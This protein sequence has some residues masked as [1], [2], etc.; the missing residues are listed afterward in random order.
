MYKL[1]TA[2]EKERQSKTPEAPV[3]NPSASGE[4]RS[5][6]SRI[7]R[8]EVSQMHK[9]LIAACMALAAFAVFAIGPAT[10]SATNNPVVTHPTN[11]VLAKGAKITGTLLNGSSVLWN[12]AKTVKQLTC[13]T[14]TMEGEL[15]K[16]EGGNV[17]GSITSAIFGGTGP[18]AAG[19]PANECTG[20]DNASVTPL[21]FP[22]C[23]RSTTTMV[24]D[25]VQIS[26]GG[27]PGGGKIKFLL[28][29]TTIGECEYESTG[30]IKGTFTTDTAANGNSDAIIHVNQPAHDGTGTQGF[31]K[32]R[33][34]IF[35]PSSGV[36]EMSFTLETKSANTEPLYFS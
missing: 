3:S 8:K 9:K 12:T 34:G 35:C 7:P 10:A 19:E 21:G 32:I 30:V 18:K 33:G 15:T 25:E 6:Q 23:I 31:K 22:W 26:G 17:E 14:A 1:P 16:N 20:V 4:N 5:G 2:R 24:T 13:T 29:T 11:T 27:C 36:L 28:L